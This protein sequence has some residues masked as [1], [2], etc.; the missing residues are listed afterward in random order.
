[1]IGIGGS[2]RNWP[3]K[4]ISSSTSGRY[5]REYAEGRAQEILTVYDDPAFADLTQWRREQGLPPQPDLAVISA[6]LDF[7]VPQVLLASGTPDID[8]HSGERR[9]RADE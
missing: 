9:P 7:P 4:P 2:F 8:L 6:S 3:F 5:L 1:M